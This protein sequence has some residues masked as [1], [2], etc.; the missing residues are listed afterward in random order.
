M[1]SDA[2]SQ[3]AGTLEHIVAWHVIT[4]HHSVCTG[5]NTEMLKGR[6]ALEALWYQVEL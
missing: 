2:A 4:L 6:T 5:S 1:K 3:P